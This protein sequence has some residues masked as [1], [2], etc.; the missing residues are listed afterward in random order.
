MRMNKGNDITIAA[1]N[2][3]KIVSITF[4][5]TSSSYLDE[6]EA[7]L[8]TTEY[9]DTYTVNGIECTIQLDNVDSIKLVNGNK[10][11]RIASVK[12]VYESA[13]TTEA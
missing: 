5:T 2:G 11:Q 8:Q 3:N 6:L 10:V 7:F 1:K 9:K 12:I 4:V 13:S